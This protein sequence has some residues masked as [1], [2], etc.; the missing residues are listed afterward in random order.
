MY[1]YRLIAK[2]NGKKVI[3]A[4][5][6]GDDAGLYDFNIERFKTENGEDCCGDEKVPCDEEKCCGGSECQ[7]QP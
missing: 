2:K 3:L 6:R 4:E 5:Y 1:G 7:C